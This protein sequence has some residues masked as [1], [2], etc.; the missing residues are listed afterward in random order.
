MGP[1]HRFEVRPRLVPGGVGG[2]S[3]EEMRVDALHRFLVVIVGVVVLAACGESGPPFEV[4]TDVI[5]GP[6]TRDITVWEPDG[7][8]PW[9]VI[10][11]VPGSGGSA[12]RDFDVFAQELA[13]HGVVV[14]GTDFVM[15]SG[16]RD[17]ECGYRFMSDT[18]AEHGGDLTRPI[19]FLGYSAG[20]LAAL[21]HGLNGNAYGPDSILDVGCPPGAQRPGIVVALNGCFL[22]WPDLESQVRFWDN[23][24]AEITLISADG[25]E[26]CGSQ[27]SIEARRILSDEGFDVGYVEIADANHWEVVFHDLAYGTYSTLDADLSAGQETIQAVLNAMGIADDGDN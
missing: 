22:T 23:R 6:G 26:V 7:E 13:S 3:R 20:A 14:F 9:P 24:D 11:V 1:E 12:M 8:G 25:D 17:V 27:H 21:D 18:V 15:A 19:T 2:A 16:K 5:G 10:Y 4:S